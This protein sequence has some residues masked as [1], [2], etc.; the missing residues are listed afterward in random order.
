MATI[1]G[2][3]T[4]YLDNAT[5]GGNRE[6]LEDVIHD[7]FPEDTWALSNLDKTSASATFHE[8]LADEPAAAAANAQLEGDD[9]TFAAIVQPNRYGNY[10]QIMNK[11]FIISGTQERVTKAG[12][13]SE[14]GRQAMKKMR[15]LKRDVEFSLT[16]NAAGT[17]GGASTARS[18]AGMESWITATTASSANATVVVLSTTSASATTAPITGGTPAAPTDSGTLAALTEADLKLAL[19]GAWTNG[20]DVDTILAAPTQKAVIDGLSGVVTRN[21]DIGRTEQGVITAANNVY[22]SSFGVHR[23][24]QHR[25]MRTETVLCLD[26]SLW[27]IATLRPFTS[28]KLAKTGDAEKRLIQTEMC[29]VARNPKGNAKVVA[30]S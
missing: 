7:L 18:S 13:K 16:R 30:L 21:I 28:E 23:V 1:T 29:L 2:T 17:A 4:S 19:E 6:D 5:T 20:G 15:E 8:W 27:A 11:T 9:S 22:V 3:S 10:T 26:S 14:I 24:V 12:R 25:Y